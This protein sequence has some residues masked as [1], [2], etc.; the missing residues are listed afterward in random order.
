MQGIHSIISLPKIIFADKELH[1][2]IA[3]IMAGIRFDSQRRIMNSILE[4]AEKDGTN[5]YVFTCDAWTYS[6]SQYNR[7]ETNVFNLPSFEKFDGVIMHADT[8]CNQMMMD[9]VAEEVRLAKTPGVSL[10]IHYDDMLYVGMENEYGISQLIDHLVQVHGVRKI[11]F[12]SGP[13]GNE[14]AEGRLKAYR[15][16]MQRNGLEFGEKN[17]YHGDYHPE[18]GKDAVSEFCDYYKEVPEAIVAANDEMALGAFYELQKRGYRVPE[19]VKLT[20]YD[21]TL[22][23]RNH[24]PKLTSV[25]R[26]ELELG[27]KAYEKLMK[28]IRREPVDVT[29]EQLNSIPVYTDTC[30]CKDSV[31]EDVKDFR[32]IFVQDKLHVTTFAE[33]IK[34]SSVD[35]TGVATFEQ[36]K[37][38]I[39]K[40]ISM[41]DPEGF[42][43]CMNINEEN[44]GGEIFAKVNNEVPE[45]DVTRYT[46]MITVPIAYEKGRFDSYGS[47]PREQLL[48]DKYLAN[49]TGMLYTVI[50]M[51]FQERSFGYCVLANSRLMIDSEVF[52][53]FIMNI[54]NAIE[55]IRKQDMLNNMVDRL[56]RM[57]VYDTLTNIFNRAGLFKFAPNIL[58][59]AVRKNQPIFALFL[60]LDGL[61]AVNDRYGHDEGDAYIKAMANVLSQ[62]HR[63]GDLLIR[64]GGD[65]F[66]VFSQGYTNQDAEEYI[67][68]IRKGMENY[69]AISRHDYVLD[70]S[71]GYT[72]T[73]ATEDIDIEEVIERA[74]QE[75]Y[76]EKYKKKVNR[77]R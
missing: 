10:N 48:P 11:N 74:D 13:A 41:I 25:K 3:V 30:G 67:T 53:L 20:G 21:Y 58:G 5:I 76:K 44:Y 55:N 26:P 69:N 54:N 32:R 8:V 50:P 45:M 43:M 40:Y 36:L 39:R 16:S 18:S 59:E 2:N 24:Y 72:I 15:E 38:N 68:E 22:S 7:G 12:I 70:A 1:M 4:E 34:S 28:V 6:A 52:H 56:N 64:Y 49:H 51:H 14:D 19:D 71:I 23:A 27:K 29:D 31:S 73:A 17:I 35:F 75:M 33:I 42:Y 9:R 63:H 77:G 62:V 47:F 65:E 61:K 37:K 66:V 57:W 46:D 60:D